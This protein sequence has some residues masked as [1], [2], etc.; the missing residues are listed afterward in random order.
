MFFKKDIIKSV[1]DKG[2]VP[3]CIA[4]V[5]D[6][7]GRWAQRRGL[8]RTAGHKMGVEA[9]KRITESCIK[10]GVQYII[11]YAFST[12]N[13]KRP[14]E[15]VDFLMKLPGEYLGTELD[16]IIKNNIRIET[17]GDLSKLP[18]ETKETMEV[19]IKKSQSNTGLNLVF[20]INYGSRQ[21]IVNAVNLTLENSKENHIEK[22]E[23]FSRFMDTTLKSIP[24]P[25]LFIRPGGEYR[26][27]NFL[28]WQL[29]YTELFFTDTLWPDFNEKHLCKAIQSYQNRERR[30]G[31]LKK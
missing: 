14:K 26:V 17:I 3:K 5:M 8:P 11:L 15:E 7:N 6:G 27:S 1:K 20:A 12:E 21:E 16:K 23:D 18:A 4:I 25:D 13:W 24:D 29:A 30:F 2:N 28:L 10:L 9:L 22:E 31:G 19:A